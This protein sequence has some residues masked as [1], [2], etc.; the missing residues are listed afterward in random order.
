[1]ADIVIA[2]LVIVVLLFA[3]RGTIKHFKGEGGCCGGG[4]G[5]TAKKAAKKKLAGPVIDRKIVHIS[6]MHCEHCAVRVTRAINEIEGASAKVSLKRGEA[7]VSCDRNVE[8]KL[9]CQ[10]IEQAG[11]R[12]VSIEA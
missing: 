2:L 12:V 4:G 6:G 9:V 8:A 7:V 5:S 11:Y 3:L 10:A 1:M